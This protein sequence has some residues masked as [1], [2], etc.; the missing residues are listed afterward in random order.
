[1]V[2][3]REHIRGGST[4]LDNDIR[5]YSHSTGYGA[6]AVYAT[7]FLLFFVTGLVMARAILSGDGFAL[8]APGII[9]LVFGA[10]LLFILI[11]LFANMR[12]ALRFAKKPVLVFDERGITDQTGLFSLELIHWHEIEEIFA[13]RFIQLTLRVERPK[14]KM[15]SGSESGTG[16]ASCHASVCWPGS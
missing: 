8:P 13:A 6:A 5:I 12:Y 14:R 11:L 9:A 10:L 4:F 1:M 2:T 3:A 7:F 16:R 15:P